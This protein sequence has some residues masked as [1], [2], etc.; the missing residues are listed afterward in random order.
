MQYTKSSTDKRE[1]KLSLTELGKAVAMPIVME[2]SAI[3]QRTAEQFGKE[4]LSDLL[5]NLVK[6]QRLFAKNL[7]QLS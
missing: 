2:L 6:L 3:E 7:E 5:N 1:K 4:Q